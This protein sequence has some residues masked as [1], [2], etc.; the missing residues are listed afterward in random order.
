MNPQQIPGV[1]ASKRL[2]HPDPR[3]SVLL[4]CWKAGPH[5]I[6]LTTRS[7]YTLRLQEELSFRDDEAALQA[8]EAKAKDL[9]GKGY[10]EAR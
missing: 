1:L 7:T 9:L 8:L 2:N 10:E 3:W 5:D 6:R 4:T